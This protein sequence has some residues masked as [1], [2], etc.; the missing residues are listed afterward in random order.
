MV[1]AWSLLY[2]EINGTM[3]ETYPIKKEGKMSNNDNVNVTI[4]NT[5]SD[6]GTID[7]TS[8]VSF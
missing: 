6:D 5:A 1:N 4:G 8:D 3:D 7:F 2:E